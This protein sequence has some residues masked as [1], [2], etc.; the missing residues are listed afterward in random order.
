MDHLAFKIEKGRKMG[1]TAKLSKEFVRNL[2]EIEIAAWSDFYS[3]TSQEIIK[4]FGI[5]YKLIDGLL[6]TAAS[7]VDALAMNRV[8]GLGVNRPVTGQILQDIKDYYKELNIPRFFIQLC[9]TAYNDK[10]KELVTDHG[11]Q[12]YN[13]W[14]RSYRDTDI[15][16]EVNTALRVIRIKAKDADRFG[17]IITQ[18]FGWP[19]GLKYWFKDIAERAGWCLYMTYNKELPVATAAMFTKGDSSW[20][21]MA[22][23]LQ[24]YR[25]LGAQSA[26]ISR[27][28]K[29]AAKKGCKLLS[30]ETAEDKPDH[31]APSFHNVIRMGFHEAYKRMNFIYKM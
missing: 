19:E 20:F 22:S 28:I 27:R 12:H 11:F 18:S 25:K 8:V 7:K 31:P 24:E 2:E 6:F 26:L 21:G 15:P 4:Q 30:V 17:S 29:E 1:T 23:T 5:Q 9:P 10:I 16:L 3:N 13:N 14:V